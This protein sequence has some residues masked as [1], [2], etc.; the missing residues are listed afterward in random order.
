MSLSGISGDKTQSNYG[1]GNFWV[2]KMDSAG[3]KL[4]DRVYGGTGGEQLL[5][6]LNTSHGG[7][8]LGGE[9]G[10]P[11]SGDVSQGKTGYWVIKIDSAGNKIW[12]RCFG[13][14]GTMNFR[15]MTATNDGGYLLTGESGTGIYGDKTEA[16]LGPYQVWVVRIDSDGN[17]IWDKTIFSLGGDQGVETVQTSDGCYVVAVQTFAGIG[18]YKTQPNWDTTTATVTYDYWIV[19]LCDTTI[20]GIFEKTGDINFSIYPNPTANDVSIMLQK[21]GLKEA[22]FTLTNVSGQIIYQSDETH[23]SSTYTKMLDLTNLPTGTY[24]LNVNADG[25]RISRKIVKE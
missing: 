9:S 17:K 7:Y 12:D 10:S 6:I 11:I 16:N 14:L 8:L 24:F 19:K 23:L 15:N 18:G 1:P 5:S 2:V 4:W 20:S 25:E 3:N 21:D 13:G 22:T